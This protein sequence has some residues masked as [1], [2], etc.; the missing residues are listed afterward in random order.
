M[1]SDTPRPPPLLLLTQPWP[2]PF[3]DR[4]QGTGDGPV[5]PDPSLTEG[6]A[7]FQKIR[8]T[9]RCAEAKGRGR[10]GPGPSLEGGDTGLQGR[11]AWTDRPVATHSGPG[12]KLHLTGI[13]QPCPRGL[14]HPHVP[15]EE[16]EAQQ[17][18]VAGPRPQAGEGARPGL[19]PRPPG[20][21]RGEGGFPIGLSLAGRT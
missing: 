12:S 15:D 11:P 5:I 17:P 6:S 3:P 2:G 1:E 10:P 14:S 19:V 13:H 21:T 7:G 8:R 9:E 18:W 4:V 16:T 20:A